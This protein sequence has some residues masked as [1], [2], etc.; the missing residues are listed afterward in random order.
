M[1]GKGSGGARD[2]RKRRHDDKRR[3]R[4]A[5]DPVVAMGRALDAFERHL[6]TA[7]GRNQLYYAEAQALFRRLDT[8]SEQLDIA[9]FEAPDAPSI[10]E[11]N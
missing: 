7:R 1:G 5:A 10:E 2:T 9:T 8:L 11:D 6:E 4:P 3:G